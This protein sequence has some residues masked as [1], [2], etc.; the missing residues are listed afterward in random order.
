MWISH[1]YDHYYLTFH[2]SWIFVVPSSRRDRQRWL[3]E[4]FHRTNAAGASVPWPFWSIFRRVFHGFSIGCCWKSLKTSDFFGFSQLSHE[5]DR[6][7]LEKLGFWTRKTVLEKHVF[8]FHKMGWY[9]WCLNWW[10][11]AQPPE[12]WVICHEISGVSLEILRVDECL[13]GQAPK[14]GI[15]STW[16]KIGSRIPTLSPDVSR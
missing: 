13:I 10:V 7:C 9:F 8:L 12:E 3:Q 16:I 14:M 15:F 6:K 11:M 4:S 5:N 2:V 1:Q